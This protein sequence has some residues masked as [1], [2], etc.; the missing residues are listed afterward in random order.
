MRVLTQRAA[1]DLLHATK[2]SYFWGMISWTEALDRLLALQRM[3]ANGDPSG[4]VAARI[5][6]LEDWRTERH[7][8]DE[9]PVLESSAQNTGESSVRRVSVSSADDDGDEDGVIQFIPASRTGLQHWTFHQYDADWHP[10]IPHGHWHGNSTPK[11][12]PYQGWVYEG[13][14]QIR[15]ES[16]SSI[17]S[18][19]NDA[20]FRAFALRAIQY[21][22]DHFP[23]YAGWRVANPFRLPRRR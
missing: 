1:R 23:H 5:L 21:Y 18:I 9:T 8:A 22:V 13:S 15:R 6:L 16:R 2:V 3:C 19:W 10:T 4:V 17:V 7:W 20:A 11:L 12:D 14:A